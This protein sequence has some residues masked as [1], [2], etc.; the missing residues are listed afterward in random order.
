M[1]IVFDSEFLKEKCI[2]NICLSTSYRQYIVRSIV[3]KGNHNLIVFIQF[4]KEIVRSIVPKGNHNYH[5][6]MVFLYQLLEVLYRK[7][8]T[9]YP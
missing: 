5:R 8:I 4:A 7:V 9:T 1:D 3:P 6:G 2:I